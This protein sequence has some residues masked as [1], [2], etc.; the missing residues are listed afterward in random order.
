MMWV[1]KKKRDE[2]GETLKYKAR[3][4]VCGN[5]QKRK[6]TAAGMEHTLETF[7]PAARSATFKLLC[8]GGCIA[9]LRVRQF[10]VEAAYLQG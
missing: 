6:A 5:Q 2:K 7:L 8:A 3:T 9:N 4:V 10:D 1:L